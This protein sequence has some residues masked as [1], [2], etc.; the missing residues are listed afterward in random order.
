MAAGNS[1]TTV[2][3]NPYANY[4]VSILPRGDSLHDYD[5]VSKEV[6]LYPGN[7]ETVSFNAI[8][9]QVLLGK[10]VDQN[11]DPLANYS[12]GDGDRISRT[13]EFGL[14]QIRVPETTGTLEATGESESCVINIPENYSQRAGIGIVGSLECDAG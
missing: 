7:V 4:Q 12:L 6:T 1:R 9:Q 10:L 14:F 8:K 5:P 2:P 11:G 3:L 13:D